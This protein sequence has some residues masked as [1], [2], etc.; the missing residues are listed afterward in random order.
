MPIHIIW[1]DNHHHLRAAGGASKML[2]ANR[3]DRGRIFCHQHPLRVP[4]SNFRGNI[5]HEA[6]GHDEEAVPGHGLVP[7]TSGIVEKRILRAHPVDEPA[8]DA[9][10]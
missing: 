9:P 8:D 5:H 2:P 6:P 3:A 4:A 7:E 1:L 10:A